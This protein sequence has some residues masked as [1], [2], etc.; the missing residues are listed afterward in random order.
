M[1]WK[2]LKTTVTYTIKIELIEAIIVIILEATRQKTSE[3]HM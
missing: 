1:F 3:E 2:F